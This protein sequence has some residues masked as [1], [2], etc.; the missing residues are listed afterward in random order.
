MREA[1]LRPIAGPA[2]TPALAT[3]GGVDVPG[4]EAHPELARRAPGSSHE[5]TPEP[6][7]GEWDPTTLTHR[8]PGAIGAGFAGANTPPPDPHW[9]DERTAEEHAVEGGGRVKKTTT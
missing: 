4:H 3:I 2:S 7:P 6:I 5:D 1:A 8:E 9:V